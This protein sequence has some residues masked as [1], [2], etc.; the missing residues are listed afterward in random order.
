[1]LLNLS[2]TIYCS[3]AVTFQSKDYVSLQFRIL[4]QI[5]KHITEHRKYIKQI[6]YMQMYQ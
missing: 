4:L 2:H 1:M 3:C 6:S 5:S